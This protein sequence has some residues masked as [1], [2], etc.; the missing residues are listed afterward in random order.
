MIPAAHRS[1]DRRRDRGVAPA[2]FSLDLTS[3]PAARLHTMTTSTSPPSYL[4]P[5]TDTSSRPAHSPTTVCFVRE[6]WIPHP[7]PLRCTW[8]LP[9]ALPPFGG[10]LLPG[11]LPGLLRAYHYTSSARGFSECNV[12]CSWERVTT[13][14]WVWETPSNAPPVASVALLSVAEVATLPSPWI[15]HAPRPLRVHVAFAPILP[16]SRASRDLVFSHD[17]HQVSASEGCMRRQRARSCR[18]RCISRAHSANR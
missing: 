10:S 2:A 7:P 14:A 5:I 1:R 12:E 6:T 8:V 3:A 17:A 18:S 11:P 13:H 15:G 4:P 9:E 16:P